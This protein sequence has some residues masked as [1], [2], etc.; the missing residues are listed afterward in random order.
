MCYLFHGWLAS[1]AET[2]VQLIDFYGAGRE[3]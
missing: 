2:W 3:D 1:Y